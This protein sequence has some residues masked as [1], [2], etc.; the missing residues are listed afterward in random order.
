MQNL[1]LKPKQQQKII[2][3]V[4]KDWFTFTFEIKCILNN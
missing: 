4:P 2:T 1:K 3:K